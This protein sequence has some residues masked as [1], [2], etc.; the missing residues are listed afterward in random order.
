MTPERLELRLAVLKADEGCKKKF[1]GRE[2]E[3]LAAAAS[4]MLATKGGGGIR[5]M[6]SEVVAHTSPFARDMEAVETSVDKFL[7]PQ[8]YTSDERSLLDKG[9]AFAAEFNR[10]EDALTKLGFGHKLATGEYCDTGQRVLMRGK[11]E[12]NATPLEAVSYYMGHTDGYA[13]RKEN[14]RA[15]RAI[16]FGER[17]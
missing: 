4:M 9:H 5:R 8:A 2:E 13:T 12:L 1:L 6:G 10:H 16:T 7:L 3:L 14:G 15:A 17:R 11:W